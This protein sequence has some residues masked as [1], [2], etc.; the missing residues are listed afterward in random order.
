M[1]ILFKGIDVHFLF[2]LRLAGCSLNGCEMGPDTRGEET[3]GRIRQAMHWTPRDRTQARGAG[4][5][6]S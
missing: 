1:S 5:I 2:L 3:A 4:G 6:S